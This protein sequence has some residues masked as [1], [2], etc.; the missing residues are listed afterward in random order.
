MVIGGCRDVPSS[1]KLPLYCNVWP[2]LGCKPA[3]GGVG[4]TQN[5]LKGAGDLQEGD[6]NLICNF[7][8]GIKVHQNLE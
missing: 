6:L 5:H 2:G 4:G 7:T 8:I 3:P 1:C